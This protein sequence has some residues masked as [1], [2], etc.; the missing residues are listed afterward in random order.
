MARKKRFWQLINE[1]FRSEFNKGMY[2]IKVQ[3]NQA[4]Q[5][6]KLFVD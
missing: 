2:I 4:I 6:T 5:T 1:S 3:S